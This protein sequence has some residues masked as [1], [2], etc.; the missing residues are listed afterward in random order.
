MGINCLRTPRSI[1][2][3]GLEV[4][5]LYRKRSG[6]Q[7]SPLPSS[8][9]CRSVS[10]T[11]LGLNADTTEWDDKAYDWGVGELGTSLPMP[12]PSDLRTSH[13][14]SKDRLILSRDH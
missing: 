14:L 6:N 2:S 3:S 11:A 13:G 1:S 9:I 10:D 4:L 12:R 8:L 7:E 5:G